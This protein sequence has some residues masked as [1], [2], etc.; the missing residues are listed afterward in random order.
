M[1]RKK[2]NVYWFIVVIALGFCA[3]G[4]SNWWQVEVPSGKVL[5]ASIE[6]NYQVDMARMRAQQ[7][8]GK[9]NLS[10]DWEQK[11]KQAIRA[12]LLA[13]SQQ[14]KDMARSW[15]FVG[16]ALLVFSLGRIVAQPLFGN[17]ENNR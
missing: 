15:F 3:Y 5:E 4:A 2:P 17:N 12:E 8:D 14:E 16:L 11:H 9:L 10:D 13:E 7:R 6:A 1:S